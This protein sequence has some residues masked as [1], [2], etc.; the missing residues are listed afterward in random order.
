MCV[1]F[2][3]CPNLSSFSPPVPPGLQELPPPPSLAS[4]ALSFVF[5]WPH[6]TCPMHSP[7]LQHPTRTQASRPPSVPAS[8]RA[9]LCPHTQ[10]LWQAVWAEGHRTTQVSLQMESPQPP[11]PA[12]CSRRSG[13][14]A[15]LSTPRASVHC[16]RRVLLPCL[17][18]AF[19]LGCT[20]HFARKFQGRP[21]Q[22]AW[23]TNPMPSHH[24]MG[25]GVLV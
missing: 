23:K 5:R 21:R 13:I 3:P 11:H 8:G 6:M 4:L 7:H 24:R 10:L 12:A 18:Q 1:F 15:T 19:S 20:G 9:Y 17:A 2:F 22:S 16:T 14:K 25:Q